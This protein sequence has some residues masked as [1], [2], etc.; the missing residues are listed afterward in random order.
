MQKRFNEGKYQERLKS[1]EF[2]I[3]RTL[4]KPEEDI[5]RDFGDVI[6]VGTFCFDDDNN[7]VFYSHHYESPSGH[8]LYRDKEHGTV[9]L[10]GRMDPKR[11]L[12]NGVQYHLPT[13]KKPPVTNKK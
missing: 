10:D 11:I 9:Y 1:G 2:R 4:H 7:E 12:E 3:E 13:K 8:V 5:L 6:S